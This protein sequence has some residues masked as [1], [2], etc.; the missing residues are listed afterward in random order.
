MLSRWIFIAY[1][2]ADINKFTARLAFQ[3]ATMPPFVAAI[4]SDI[5]AIYLM[6]LY[7]AYARTHD[8]G[9]YIFWFDIYFLDYWYVSSKPFSPY[10]NGSVRMRLLLM[11]I[12]LSLFKVI[13]HAL[14][15]TGC[16]PCNATITIIY[17][18]RA[19]YHQNTTSMSSRSRLPLHYARH[20]IF[21]SE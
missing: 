14:Y 12:W 17:N 5:A 10:D 3:N 7:Y 15:Y 4:N 6:W 13:L 20:G 11:Q 16:L 18:I 9:K 21:L 2:K 19:A 8:E 1:T